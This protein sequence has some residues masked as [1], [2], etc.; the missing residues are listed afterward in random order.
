MFGGW[1]LEAR[2]AVS[3]GF[4]HQGRNASRMPLTEKWRSSM[5]M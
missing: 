2:M 3:S 5:F 4:G 1:L